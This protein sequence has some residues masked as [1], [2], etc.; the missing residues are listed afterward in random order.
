MVYEK[1]T[2]LLT[3]VER[4][5]RA[6][7][8][9]YGNG[10]QS[11]ATD[12]IEVQFTTNH[13][14]SKY[15]QILD[16]YADTPTVGTLDVMDTEMQAYK[17][18]P[19]LSQTFR[20]EIHV[21]V[22]E[23]AK[24]ESVAEVATKTISDDELK[25]NPLPATRQWENETVTDEDTDGGVYVLKMKKPLLIASACVAIVMVLF[26]SLLIVNAVNIATTA[27]ELQ[28]QEQLLRIA[29]EK[30]TAA[31]A[32]AAQARQEVINE[33]QAEIAAGGGN[34]VPLRIGHIETVSEYQEPI[35][36]ESRTNAFDIIC[37]FF[38]K[39]FG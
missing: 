35:D 10:P 38:S 32:A 33:L 1:D 15:N 39:L 31:A 29:E 21:P 8:F 26:V 34:L 7:D 23:V 4:R 28:Q 20:P 37:N 9:L 14:L 36:Y 5:M 3:P 25:T 13:D 22:I 18:E 27:A 16:R 24:P 11:T 2:E 30:Y 17:P 19:I 6:S 12:D